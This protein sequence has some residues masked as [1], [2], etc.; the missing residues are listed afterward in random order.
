MAVEWYLQDLRGQYGP[1]GTAE[2]RKKL[3]NYENLENVLI[4]REGFQNWRQV[5]EVFDSFETSGTLNQRRRVKGRWALYGLT[6][7][8]L[9]CPPDTTF[10]CR[11]NQFS[12][13][14]AHDAETIEPI[15]S[16]SGISTRL[17]F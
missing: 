9:I 15:I 17:L 16:T 11:R 12:P 3:R 4:W 8:V 1:L 2:L 6:G 5:P 14:N 13:L 7:G 10:E